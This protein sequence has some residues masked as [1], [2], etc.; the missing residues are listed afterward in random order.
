MP[1]V[2]T[3]KKRRK[4]VR[5]REVSLKL[6][7]NQKESLDNYCKARRT[8]NTKLIK[9]MI[10]PFLSYYSKEIPEGLYT[11]ATQLDLFGQEQQQSI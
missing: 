5:Y 11:T 4:K 7:K 10:R 3:R 2:K 1:E 6:T 9:K 8:T